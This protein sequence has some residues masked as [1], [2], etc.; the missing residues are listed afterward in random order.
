MSNEHQQGT[1]Q[2]V[3]ATY[4]YNV[5]QYVSFGVQVAAWGVTSLWLSRSRSLACRL[6]PAATHTRAA[7]WAWLGWVVPVVSWCP[8]QV[9]RDI[10]RATLRR[11]PELMQTWWTAFVL[12]WIVDEVSVW[13]VA[14]AP[15]EDVLPVLPGVNILRTVVWGFALD[16]WI[17]VRSRAHGGPASLGGCILV[18]CRA[19]M[20]PRA[21]TRV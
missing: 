20:R 19:S 13:V 9:V 1:G 21:A 8:F 11:V 15:A 12:A 17:G 16:Q 5:V 3:L 2:A 6:A 4:G 14:P 10:S 18:E 7:G